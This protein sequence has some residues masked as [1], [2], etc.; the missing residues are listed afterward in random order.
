MLKEFRTFV[1]R[2]NVVD[3]AVGVVIGAAFGAIVNGFVSGLINPVIALFGDN[4][5]QQLSFSIG[6]KA[7]PTPPPETL[8]NAFQ[9]GLMLHA[10]LN[11]LLIAAF[12][13]FFVVKP[14]NALMERF[15]AEEPTEETTRECPECLSKIP[16][17]ARR[18]MF[19]T[20]EVGA[21]G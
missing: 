14:V 15:K 1:L 5:L 21:A 19:C 2:G 16:R 12:I 3:L 10:A 11:F 18:C 17:P 13:F 8:P 20:A 4:G 6:T 7:N 9:Y